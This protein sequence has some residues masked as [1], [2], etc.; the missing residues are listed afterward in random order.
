MNKENKKLLSK[1]V[2]YFT[3]TAILMFLAPTI[4]HQAFK[5]Q[6]HN[7]YLPVLIIGIIAAITAITIG[8]YS[9]KIMLKFIFNK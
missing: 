6:D 3:F 2:K 8:F 4:I 9:L 1:A 5:N 7:L